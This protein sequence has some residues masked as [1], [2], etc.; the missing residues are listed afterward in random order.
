MN[1][2][3]SIGFGQTVYCRPPILAG[4]TFLEHLQIVKN[5]PELFIC[6]RVLVLHKHIEEVKGFTEGSTV[7]Q[8]HI[9][10]PA[11]INVETDSSTL[12]SPNPFHTLERDVPGRSE[13]RPCW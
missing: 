13:R 3:S 1:G 2:W 11:S 4:V 10:T 12:R 7:L 6:I 9:R 8:G 5:K